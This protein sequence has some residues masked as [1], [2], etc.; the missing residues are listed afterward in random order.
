MY[1]SVPSFDPNTIFLLLVMF[2]VVLVS[3]VNLLGRYN[4]I[5]HNRFTSLTRRCPN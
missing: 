4:F 3:E 5:V 1:E 2:E